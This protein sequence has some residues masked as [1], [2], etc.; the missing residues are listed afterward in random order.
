M[1][2]PLAPNV[3]RKFFISSETIQFRQTQKTSNFGNLLTAKTQSIA[4]LKNEQ[5]S[6]VFNSKR[7]SNLFAKVKV[8]CIE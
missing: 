8:F 3:R 6:T 5:I 1:T 7:N 4:P 2:R